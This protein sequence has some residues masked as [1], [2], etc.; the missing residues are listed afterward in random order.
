M[1]NNP[2]HIYLNPYQKDYNYVLP[3]KNAALSA[4][5]EIIDKVPETVMEESYH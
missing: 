3:Y 4:L 1:I 2:N 5:C